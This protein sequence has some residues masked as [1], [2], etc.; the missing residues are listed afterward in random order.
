MI[1]EPGCRRPVPP[2]DGYSVDDLYTLPDLPPHT[3]LLD[4]SLVFASP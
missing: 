2:Q 3:E 1:A 4:G